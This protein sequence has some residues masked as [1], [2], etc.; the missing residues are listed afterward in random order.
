VPR[1]HDESH[2]RRRRQLSI[3]QDQHRGGLELMEQN[4]LVEERFLVVKRRT[5][6]GQETFGM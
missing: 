5:S 4:W 2:E 1:P 6:T 3:V